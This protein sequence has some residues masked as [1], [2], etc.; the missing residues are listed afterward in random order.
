MVKGLSRHG[1]ERLVTARS[2]RP[3]SDVADLAHRARLD[4]GDLEALAAANALVSLSGHRHRA[5][6]ACSGIEPQRPLL[7]NMAVTEAAPLLRVPGEG[8][9]LVAD[10]ASVGLSLGRHPLA[11][12]RAKLTGLGLQP[13]RHILAC[14]H[15]SFTR[16][17]GIVTT[18]Q[19][20][21]SASGVMFI[22]LEDETGMTQVIIWPGLVQ[23]QRAVLLQARLLAVAGEVQ[24]EGDVIHLIA[25][26]LQDYSR[27]LGRLATQSRDFH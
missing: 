18:R 21:S 16:T 26:R 15:G 8:E 5:R 2:R 12:L 17:A 14:S 1:A 23:Q 7:E 27:L 19:S 3:F 22:T 25:K 9:E 24:R 6:W 13:A 11:L 10:H 20:P 4:R